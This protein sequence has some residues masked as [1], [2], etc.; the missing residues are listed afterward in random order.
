M[1]ENGDAIPRFFE[2]LLIVSRKWRAVHGLVMKVATGVMLVDLGCCAAMVRL[3][4]L[5]S[6]QLMLFDRAILL[7]LSRE[8]VLYED[9]ALS[10]CLQYQE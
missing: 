10:R 9:Y 7:L 5:H 6:Y 1:Q 4:V 3:R 2:E 8:S